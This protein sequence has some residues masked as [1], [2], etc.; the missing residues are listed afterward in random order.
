MPTRARTR[1][2]T[3]THIHTHTHTHRP[4]HPHT[5]THTATRTRTRAHTHT[6]THAQAGRHVTRQG[7]LSPGIPIATT[8]IE[9]PYDPRDYDDGSSSGEGWETS[10]LIYSCSCPRCQLAACQQAAC[11]PNVSPGCLSLLLTPIYSSHTPQC[12]FSFC[13]F[14]AFP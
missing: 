2:H 13:R 7:R 5:H 14:S 8:G 11:H 3:H 9:V 4:T 12:L 1:T 10:G 6:H